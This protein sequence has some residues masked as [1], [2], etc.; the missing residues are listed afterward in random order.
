V[1]VAAVVADRHGGQAS[2]A[3]SVLMV[4]VG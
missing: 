4:M 1:A 3:C 2:P